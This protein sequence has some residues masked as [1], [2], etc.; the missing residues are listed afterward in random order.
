MNVQLELSRRATNSERVLAALR[1]AGPD[2]VTNADLAELAGHRFG[3]RV[4]DL[5]QKGHG[6]LRSHVAG[7]LFRYWLAEH[8]PPGAGMGTWP[9]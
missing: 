5:R 7:G 3:G 1:Q 6:I 8:A 2:G 4:Y 9:R